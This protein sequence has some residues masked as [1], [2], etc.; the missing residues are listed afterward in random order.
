M[1]MVTQALVL[2]VTGQQHFCLLHKFR[3][4]SMHVYRSAVANMLSFVYDRFRNIGPP[5]ARV[6]PK[7]RAGHNDAARKV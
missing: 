1:Y 6:M 7:Q 5:Y 3:S 2:L 4:G